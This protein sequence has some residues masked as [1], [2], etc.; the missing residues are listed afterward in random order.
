MI[1]MMGKR[2]IV[3]ALSTGMF[4]ILV[5]AMASPA[6]ADLIG[7]S[8]T[9]SLQFGAT[10]TPNYFNPANGFVPAGFLNTA[11]PTVGISSTSTEFGLT[12]YMDAVRETH[13]KNLRDR[14]RAAEK[15]RGSA[16]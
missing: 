14:I 8:V 6:K 12:I 5:L 13:P 3:L 1:K 7:T 16:V 15:P 4:L 10:V 11:G 9:G 2:K